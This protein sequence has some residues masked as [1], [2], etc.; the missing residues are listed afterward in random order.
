M[1][2]CW[3]KLLHTFSS[4]Y[5][6]TT[7]RMYYKSFAP[8][9]SLYSLLSAIFAHMHRWIRRAVAASQW[10]ATCVYQFDTPTKQSWTME[11]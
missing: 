3:M 2:V 11:K 8:S 7:D 10:I 4:E 9:L 5:L 1:E 6:V